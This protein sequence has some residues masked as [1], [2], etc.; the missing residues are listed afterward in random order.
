MIVWVTAER[1]AGSV[2]ANYTLLRRSP[3]G[4]EEF[5]MCAWACVFSGLVL[6]SLVWGEKRG[7]RCGRREGLVACGLCVST[8][9]GPFWRVVGIGIDI[10]GRTITGGWRWESLLKMGCLNEGPVGG[11][12]LRGSCNLELLWFLSWP[13]RDRM[14]MYHFLVTQC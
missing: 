1:W 12:S 13:K 10:V 8:G 2:S 14:P 11:M 3:L 5:G 6:G 9:W 4:W 7:R